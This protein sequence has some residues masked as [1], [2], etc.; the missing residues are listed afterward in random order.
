MHK[1]FVAYPYPLYVT[2]FCDRWHVTTAK[3][4]DRTDDAIHHDKT[5]TYTRAYEGR[6]ITSATGLITFDSA[7]IGSCPVAQNLEQTLI[8]QS[9]E[10]MMFLKIFFLS[11]FFVLK[12]V[13]RGTHSIFGKLENSSSVFTIKL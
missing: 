7:K 12:K 6:S 4:T 13:V 8:Y 11:R 5:V 10:A 2:P 9:Y 3:A 1:V